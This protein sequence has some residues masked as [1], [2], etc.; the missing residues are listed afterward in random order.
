MNKK[1]I[2]K[3]ISILLLII[4]C[5]ACFF[6]VRN[7]EQAQKYEGYYLN[8]VVSFTFYNNQDAS[9]AEECFALCD[10]YEKL[11]SRTVEGSDIWNI[12]HAKGDWVTVD[13][14]TYSLLQTAC[15]HSEY[16][17]G[18]IDCTVAPLMVLWNFT[19]TT[20]NQTP[21]TEE[22][23]SNQLIHVDYRN[24]EF[25][26]GAI[27]LTDPDA[28]VDLGFIAKG[29]IGDRIKEFL[30]SEGVTSA[31]IN[32]GGNIITIGTKPDGSPYQISIRNP[33]STSD[34]PEVISV[35]DRCVTTSG[36]YERYFVYEGVSYHHILNPSTG[37]PVN[38]GLISVTIISDDAATGDALSTACLL[39]GKEKG[40]AYI[41][42]FENIN[43]VFIEEDGTITYSN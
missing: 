25:N 29:Y 28:S 5:V 4:A 43:A 19:D 8:T 18:L 27:R 11:L 21:P 16:T 38:N 41:K 23:L 33:L 31:I 36:T 10:R 7:Q 13:A 35:T 15:S 34:S 37:M 22:E 12:N 26:N 3:T 30:V 40:L 1:I 17:D 32:L 2:P 39:M 6:L 20:P 42:S 9:L 24:L 14:E